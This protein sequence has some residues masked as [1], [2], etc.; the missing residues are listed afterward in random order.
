MS[1]RLSPYQ[2]QVLEM[3]ALALRLV[4]ERIEASERRQPYPRRV[5]RILSRVR[6]R[7]ALPGYR[8]R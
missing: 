8:N 4:L 1:G 3:H 5:G 6:T 2:R 7:E